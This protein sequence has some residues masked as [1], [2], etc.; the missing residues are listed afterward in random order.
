MENP[1]ADL[2]DENQAKL[3][4][5]KL[6]INDIVENVFHITLDKNTRKQQIVYL[7][8]VAESTHQDWIDLENLGNCLF[9][10]LLL[11]EPKDYILPKNAKNP[12]DFAC[13]KEVVIYLFEIFNQLTSDQ[14]VSNDWKNRIYK[15]IFGN[16]IT[17]LKQPVLF[18]N[19]NLFDQLYDVAL[20]HENY[21]DFFNELANQ[22][23][24][25]GKI[26]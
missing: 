21:V 2:V 26:W 5:E 18:E 8:E 3:V 20:G 15:L 22:Y 14:K 23:V 11:A 16:L 10:R 9:E 12:S 1:F 19:Q 6:E 17:S 25:D 24:V 4:A 7:E 13:R